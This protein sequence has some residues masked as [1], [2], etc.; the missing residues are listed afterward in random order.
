MSLAF[1]GGRRP[2]LVADV[3]VGSGEATA[4]VRKAGGEATYMRCDVSSEDEVAALVARIE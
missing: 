3:K 4:A 1:A 2:R